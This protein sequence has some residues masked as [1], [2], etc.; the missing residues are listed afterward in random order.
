MALTS[1]R[2]TMAAIAVLFLLAACASTSPGVSVPSAA[3]SDLVASPASDVSA[4][5]ATP[6]TLTF[7]A[8]DS[9]GAIMRNVDVCFVITDGDGGMLSHGPWSTGANGEASATLRSN[10]AGA[11]EVTV[12]ACGTGSFITLGSVTVTF[13]QDLLSIDPPGV[14][15]GE[16]GTEY[17]LTFSATDIPAGVS[18]VTFNWSFGVGAAGT[19]S[20]TVTVTNGQASTQAS[21]TYAADGM[22][23]LV[24]ELRNA[25]DNSL[26]D[27]RSVTVTIGEAIERDFDLSVCDTWVAATQGGQGVT[28]DVWEI[29]D[30]PVGATFD[31]QYNAFSI[32]DRYVIEDPTGTV[33]LDT[34]WRG[35]STYEGNPLY[36][37]GIAG[38]GQGE[39]E[40]LFT[41][42]AGQNEFRVTV[43]GPQS[44]TAWNYSIRCRVP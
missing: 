22:Y 39:E 35:S 2:N 10:Q 23:G 40:D 24:V 30:I 16:V 17:T 5:G 38:P 8:R 31:I 3:Q 6:S 37:G 29:T 18:E 28:A 1:L 44:G 21:N 41:K 25:A 36:P 15:D 12:Y 32:P 9:E 26:L 34:G 20:D 4:D 27:V 42:Q 7:T 33:V 19:G 14:S 11:I 43:T 13:S